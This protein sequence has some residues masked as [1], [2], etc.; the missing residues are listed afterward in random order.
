MNQ[1]RRGHCCP[2]RTTRKGEFLMAIQK[3]TKAPTA[4]LGQ[5][6]EKSVLAQ[7]AARPLVG[8]ELVG[9]ELMFPVATKGSER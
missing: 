1:K 7:N 2:Q 3:N 5:L 4:L 6:V 9:T 8:T